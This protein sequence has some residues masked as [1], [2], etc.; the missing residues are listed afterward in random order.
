MGASLQKFITFKE[1]YFCSTGPNCYSFGCWEHSGCHF[2]IYK[3]FFECYYV[4][5]LDIEK[6]PCPSCGIPTSSKLIKC[7][8]STERI[9]GNRRRDLATKTA[10]DF[11][12]DIDLMTHPAGVGLELRCGHNF[13]REG[14]ENYI[15]RILRDPSVKELRAQ[16]PVCK[17]DIMNY[18]IQELL[19]ERTAT[20]LSMFSV[21]DEENLN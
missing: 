6:I 20:S 11:V 19:C 2:C 13:C 10:T 16:C 14:L 8:L 17:E 15:L 1:C 7:M 3:Y 5:K 12:C 21:L 18:E 9:G 4:K